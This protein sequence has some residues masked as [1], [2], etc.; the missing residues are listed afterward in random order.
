MRA[1][2]RRVLSVSRWK[3]TR[4]KSR[5]SLATAAA[6]SLFHLVA[7]LGGPGGPGGGGGGGGGFSRL[8]LDTNKEAVCKIKL[9]RNHCLSRS[10]IYIFLSVSLL[11]L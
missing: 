2:R 3:W 9:L 10:Y 4:L 6:S 8:Q 7:T 1:R 11:L 5:A